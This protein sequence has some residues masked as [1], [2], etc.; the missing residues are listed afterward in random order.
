MT[1]P[2]EG[3]IPCPVACS[4][5]RS[6]PSPS[7][8]PAGRS[9]RNESVTIDSVKWREA[10]EPFSQYAAS[11]PAQPL[12]DGRG[13]NLPSGRDDALEHV[14]RHVHRNHDH[15]HRQV[16]HEGFPEPFPHSAKALYPVEKSLPQEML[17]FSRLL[18]VETEQKEHCIISGAETGAVLL[19]WLS[20][21]GTCNSPNSA[22]TS[23][24]S[25][26]T[27]RT[28]HVCDKTSTS[29]PD[30]HSPPRRRSCRPGEPGGLFSRKSPRS[31][32]IFSRAAS[33]F[34]D[35]AQSL[36]AADRDPPCGCRC[37]F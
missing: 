24:S 33:S 8:K 1:R 21:T 22:T 14:L 16:T 37:R 2:S 11:C 27:R 15:H 25:P 28:G 7:C 13:E 9:V 5:S 12:R 31:P 35:A 18:W 4:P 6:R 3:T 30:L 17:V 19:P 34:Q 23:W 26:P 32:S 10:T 20:C 29:K 36:P